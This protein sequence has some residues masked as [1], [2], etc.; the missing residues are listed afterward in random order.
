MNYEIWIIPYGISDLEYPN[1]P[2]EGALVKDGA[3]DFG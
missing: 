1:M 2:N 3:S